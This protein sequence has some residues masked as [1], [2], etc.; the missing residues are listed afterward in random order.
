M[1]RLRR[2]RECF[3]VRLPACWSL[4]VP[5]TGSGGDRGCGE[6]PGDGAAAEEA[7][8]RCVLTSAAPEI[9]ILNS[10]DFIDNIN[11]T[12]RNTKI[13]DKP[14]LWG[15]AHNMSLMERVREPVESWGAEWFP[16]R[17]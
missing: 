2:V 4:L 12:N 14:L 7:F 15:R 16:S 1:L 11:D 13:I 10:T 8:S 6:E 5:G 9:L 3:G 17:S